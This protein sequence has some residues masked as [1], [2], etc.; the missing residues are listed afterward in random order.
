[1]WTLFIIGMYILLGYGL[2]VIA[3][4]LFVILQG[5]R[6][7]LKEQTMPCDLCHKIVYVKDTEEYFF[8]PEHDVPSKLIKVC[9][10]CSWFLDEGNGR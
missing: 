9:E 8:K 6:K 10:E 3:Y 2:A 4:Q 7:Q 5:I 1:M